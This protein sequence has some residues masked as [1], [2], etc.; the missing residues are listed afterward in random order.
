M[1]NRELNSLLRKAIGLDWIGLDWIGLDWI[2]LDWIGLDWI[3]LDWI[4]LDWIGLEGLIDWNLTTG[5]RARKGI[6]GWFVYCEV[7]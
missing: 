7:R 5:N 2:G 6:G 4:G 1:G 3:G